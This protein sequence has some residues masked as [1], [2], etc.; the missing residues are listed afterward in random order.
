[1]T[2]SS[3]GQVW[4]AGAVNK[5]LGALQL[6]ATGTIVTPAASPDRTYTVT[7]EDRTLVVLS[8]IR[9]LTVT[10]ENRLLEVT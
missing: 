3:N 9:E 7:A 8:Q 4:L 5:T 2:S 10:A 6:S 1:L